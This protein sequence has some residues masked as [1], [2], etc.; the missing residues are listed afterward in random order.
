VFV[1]VE[2]QFFVAE[3][4]AELLE[5]VLLKALEAEDVE[6]PNDVGVRLGGL[7][8]LERR[9]DAVDDNLEQVAVDRL[10]QR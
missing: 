3:V 4:D 1:E 10:G 2:L 5:A 7:R 9:V 6:H 8:K